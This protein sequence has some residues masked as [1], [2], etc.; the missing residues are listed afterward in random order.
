MK[1]QE[2]DAETTHVTQDN[3]FL[4]AVSRKVETTSMGVKYIYTF[5]KALNDP[6][7]VGDKKI[8]KITLATATLDSFPKLYVNVKGKQ[9][10]VI[11]SNPSNAYNELVDVLIKNGYL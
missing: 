3:V 11:V 8:Y 7:T 5:Y 6:F 10:D 1:L 2:V 4:A 9:Q